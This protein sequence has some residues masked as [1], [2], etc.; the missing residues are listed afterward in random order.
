MPL[1]VLLCLVWMTAYTAAG[2]EGFNDDFE[3]AELDA[4][5]TWRVPIAGPTFS[6]RE[7]PGW[8][9][10]HVP[11]RDAAYN[12]WNAP[13][14]D[15]APQLRTPAPAGN[16]RIEARLQLRTWDPA[17]HF[18]VGLLV[19][20][21]DAQILTW[22]PLLGPGI[23]GGPATPELRLEPTGSSGY[24]RMEG[25]ARD[26]VIRLT[27]LGNTFRPGAR[28]A[29]G[30]WEEGREFTFPEP[31]AFVG[32]IAKTFS[33]GPG[34]TVDVDYV[35]LEMLEGNAPMPGARAAKGERAAPNARA[36]EAMASPA[37]PAAAAGGP[38]D[39]GNTGTRGTA[40]AGDPPPDLVALG[41]RLCDLGDRHRR[42]KQYADAETCYHAVLRL[43]PASPRAKAG[44]AKLPRR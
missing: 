34:I 12:H 4:R 44:L 16:W 25:D 33:N 28:R 19:G 35:R 7:R 10:L 8:L 38:L 2:A 18:H 9:R 31:P 27:R 3:G 41:K 42:A 17:N 14:A 1:L 32:L 37:T 39:S 29:G 24:F 36:P 15:D 43:L 40:A 26:V 23:P 21:N 11:Q 30:R 22:G 20:V 5:W 6:L 13:P